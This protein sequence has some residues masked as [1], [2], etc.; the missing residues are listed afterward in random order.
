MRR[1]A[2]SSA[3]APALAF[4]LAALLALTAQGPAPAAKTGP[5]CTRIPL[6]RTGCR[7]LIVHTARGT[8][9]LAVARDRTR[10]A[11]TV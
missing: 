7:P 1:P 8:L 9:Q 6:P 10:S 4:A 3:F 5:L 11:S 2:A